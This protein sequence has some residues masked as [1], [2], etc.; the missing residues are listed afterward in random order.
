MKIDMTYFKFLTTR[1]IHSDN[2]HIDAEI[3]LQ[4]SNML[5]VLVRMRC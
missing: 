2:N 3:F 1:Q 5:F 4:Y